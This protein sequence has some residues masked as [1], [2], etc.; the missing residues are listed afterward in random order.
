MTYAVR[1][2]TNADEAVGMMQEA[3]EWMQTWAPDVLRATMRATEYA[4]DAERYRFLRDALATWAPC[5]VREWLWK[6]PF[7]T[8]GALDGVIDEAMAAAP[9]V[10]LPNV[11][12]NRESMR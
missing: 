7:E 2:P 3:V 8:G 1:T 6:R 10:V 12:A 4:K 5:P 11:R 9:A